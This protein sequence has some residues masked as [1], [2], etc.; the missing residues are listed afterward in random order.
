MDA[1]QALQD[2]LFLLSPVTMV[3]RWVEFAAAEIMAR[4]DGP[5]LEALGD[6]RP[7]ALQL[8][9]E[10][11]LRA[12]AQNRQCLHRIPLIVIISYILAESVHQR[13]NLVLLK[14]ALDE[15]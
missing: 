3:I 1:D 5:A 8:L 13:L 6:F 2:L 7:R 14:A 9:R 15:R 10:L 4:L 11:L 12:R